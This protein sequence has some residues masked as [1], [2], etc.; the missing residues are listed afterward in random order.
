MSEISGAAPVTLPA[1][2]VSQLRVG[3]FLR[4]FRGSERGRVYEV[5]RDDDLIQIRQDPIP[6]T[7]RTKKCLAEAAAE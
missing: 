1:S 2:E 6:P 3:D 7:C 5:Q 4:F